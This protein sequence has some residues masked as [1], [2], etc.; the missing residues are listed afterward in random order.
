MI[1]KNIKLKILEISDGQVKLGF[2]APDDVKIFRSEVYDQI[3]RYNTEAAKTL[4]S[5]VIQA[6]RMLKENSNK[7]VKR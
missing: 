3:E 4:K 6:A 1:S 5:T 2:E 7:N